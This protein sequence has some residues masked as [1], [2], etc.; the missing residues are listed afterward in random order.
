M[1][2][3]VNQSR[4]FSLRSLTYVVIG[5][6]SDEMQL[7]P[8]RLQWRQEKSQRESPG[9]A[10]KTCQQGYARKDSQKKQDHPKE[11]S[12]EGTASA[13]TVEET[14]ADRQTRG[15]AADQ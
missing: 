13:G 5:Q 7:A 14:T 8:R 11:G 4:H 10:Q 6:P 3:A 12:E 15:Y 1:R 9:K 2:H